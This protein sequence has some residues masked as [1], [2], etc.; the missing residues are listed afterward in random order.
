MLDRNNETLSRV[1][2]IDPA[3]DPWEQSRP[4]PLLVLAVFIA[5]AMWGAMRY[6][7]DLALERETIRGGIVRSADAKMAGGHDAPP[8]V[9][10]GNTT[11]WSCASCHGQAGEGAGQTPGLARLPKPYIAKQ[12]RDFAD[13]ARKNES[14]Q[15]VARNLTASEIESASA[16]YAA[17]PASGETVRDLGADT[18]RGKKLVQQG[19]WKLG[20]PAC[21]TCHGQEGKGVG[22]SFPRLAG[23]QPEYLLSQLAAWKGGNRHNSPQA[24][25]DDIASRMSNEDMVAVAQYYGSLK[26]AE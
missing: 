24:L 15:Y 20:I 21:A 26:F 22:S 2:D 4:I 19:D 1:E 23:Q 16:Y 5:L 8:I 9:R 12:L 25:M 3:F 10:L 7:G 6:L 13:G 11:V 14:M 17:L 18:K